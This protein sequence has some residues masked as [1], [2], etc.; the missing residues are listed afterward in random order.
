M[1]NHVR[2]THRRGVAT[3]LID[4]PGTRNAIDRAAMATLSDVLTE[5]EQGIDRGDV[6]VVAVRGGGD[7][8]FISGGDLKEL[9]QIRT[10]DE[11]TAMSRTMRTVLDRLATLPVP[12]VALLNGDAYGGGAEVAVACDIRLGAADIKFGFNQ[13]S[14]GIMPAWGGVERLTR[15]VGRGRAMQLLLTGTILTAEDAM[16]MN[17]IELVAPRGQFDSTADA[18]L[19]QLASVPAA[20]R[21]AIKSLVGAVAPASVPE[22]ATVASAEFARS[23][24]ADEH[25]ALVDAA[26]ARRAALKAGSP[27]P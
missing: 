7:R 12:T 15:L 1:S 2:V 9:A 11:A 26:G 10:E 6:S 14:L 19:D 21:R 17:L 16:A 13:V 18:L 22:L 4:R 23:W 3:V 27:P 20:P 24:V 25:W 5:L 8:V